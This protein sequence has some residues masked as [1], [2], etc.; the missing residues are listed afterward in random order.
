MYYEVY[1][2]FVSKTL[3]YDKFQVWLRIIEPPWSLAC[4]TQRRRGPAMLIETLCA[5]MINVSQ[6]RSASD[7]ATFACFQERVV[8]NCT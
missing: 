3:P 5:W 8:R 2:I 6:D 4:C 1:Y 7:N